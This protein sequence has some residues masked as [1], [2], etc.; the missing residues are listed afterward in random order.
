M[1]LQ[2]ARRLEHL[3]QLLNMPAP[4]LET[5]MEFSMP[6]FRL[7]LECLEKR[8]VLSLGY[9][10]DVVHQEETLN[11]LLAACHPA[12]T[13]GTPLRAYSLRGQQMLSCS[14]AIDSDATHWF[15]CLQVMRRL[16]EAHSREH[17]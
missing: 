12:R 14:P 17:R 3:L 16:L 5:Q 7:Y 13:Q 15:T 11:R 8:L 6:P 4:Q 9:P 1:E 2:T 10:V